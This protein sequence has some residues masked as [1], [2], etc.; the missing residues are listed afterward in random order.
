MKIQQKFENLKNEIKECIM[1]E[2]ETLKALEL[3]MLTAEELVQTGYLKKNVDSLFNG[4]EMFNN[5]DI[6][7]YFNMNCAPLSCAELG[8]LYF[9]NYNTVGEYIDKFKLSAVKKHIFIELYEFV[10]NL[11]ANL[12][13]KS[14]EGNDI[15]DKFDKPD[16]SYELPF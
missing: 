4:K 9:E 11:K 12:K 6:D 5:A 1:S 10:Y 16:D 13:K 8:E 15:K 3:K 2:I 7:N 14:Q